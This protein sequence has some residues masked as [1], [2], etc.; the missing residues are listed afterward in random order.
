MALRLCALM[1]CLATVVAA[2]A[3]VTVQWNTHAP[4]PPPPRT[5]VVSSVQG[6]HVVLRLQD[7]TLRA[8]DAT[9]AQ[10]KLLRGLVGSAIRYRVQ[11]R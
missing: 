9:P 10:A 3:S 6:T 4:I 2:N 5:A 11:A 8:F 1:A 7:G